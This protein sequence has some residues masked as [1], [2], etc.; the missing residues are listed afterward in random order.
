MITRHVS[1]DRKVQIALSL[2]A[3]FVLAAWSSSA[4]AAT[5]VET[6]CDQ[7][8]RSADMPDDRS[9]DLKIEVVDHGP[10]RSSGAIDRDP[11][12]A[13]GAARPQVEVLLRRI[14]D[15]PQLRAVDADQSEQVEDL[16]APLAVDQVETIEEAAKKANSEEAGKT[17]ADLPGVSAD[18]L[19]RFKR[20]MYRTDI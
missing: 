16:A 17:S 9:S 1:L 10:T 12:E 18:D 13:D 2:L 20:R 4:L 6:R 11:V 8:V 15:E 5:G 3:L 14:F 19:L 7:S